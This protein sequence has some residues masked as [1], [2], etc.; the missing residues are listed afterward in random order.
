MAILD[1]LRLHSL[2]ELRRAFLDASPWCPSLCYCFDCEPSIELRSH[3]A[4]LK[5][6]KRAAAIKAAVE[7]LSLDTIPDAP[8]CITA[9]GG[10]ITHSVESERFEF[11]GICGTGRFV[12]AEPPA[13]EPTPP[14]PS[15]Y[16]A[17]GSWHTTVTI[18]FWT[19]DAG[20]KQFEELSREAIG[21]WPDNRRE[22]GESP[23]VSW[24]R[25]LYRHYHD[26][27]QLR[28]TLLVNPADGFLGYARQ[29][30]LPDN[31]FQA[32]AA[33]IASYEPAAT[34]TNGVARERRKPTGR[35]PDEFITDLANH[36]R[37]ERKMGLK[38][39]R[40]LESCKRQFKTRKDEITPSKIANALKL[41]PEIAK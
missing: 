29:L 13:I 14:T 12:T 41:R 3:I 24:L 26:A 2:L 37:R 33:L 30:W 18:P 23:T 10:E 20:R 4:G 7:A 8:T 36:V 1:S 9:G 5:G 25:V 28:C 17:A 27:K 32:S 21:L 34:V 11:D 40:V 16:D 38:G 22:V 19:L 15:G 31:V 6:K 35:E 39:Q